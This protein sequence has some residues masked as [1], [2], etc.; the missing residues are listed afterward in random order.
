MGGHALK[1]KRIV[2]AAYEQ[3]KKEIA[4]LFRDQE[5]V[6]IPEAPEKQDYG[7]LDI[8]YKAESDFGKNIYQY[9]KEIL[10][11]RE[12]V[13]NGDVYSCDY[14]DFQIDFIRCSNFEMSQF[15]FSYGDFG[16]ILG[17]IVNQY[18]LKFGQQGLWMNIH[19]DEGKTH[20]HGRI[21][22][23]NEPKQ[24]CDFLG[25]KYEIWKAGFI[26][27]QD[28]F[29]FVS[30]CRLFHPTIFRPLNNRTQKR[31]MYIE[32]LDFIAVLPRPQQQHTQER[33]ALQDEALDFF[34]KRP[35]YTKMMD[36]LETQ[37]QRKEKY[38]GRIFFDLGIP[39]RS[40]GHAMEAFKD[41]HPQLDEWIDQNTAA[42]ILSAIQNFCLTYKN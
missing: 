16:G 36:D 33:R 42:T 31:T 40:I 14:K 24:I 9:I 28:I 4:L 7:D 32:F 20:S 25:L 18:N 21:I 6:F 1:T 2:P 19:L 12:I 29:K 39:E 35:I 23:S 37:R 17:C 8:L 30:Q 38:N 5:I 22:L 34:V 11:P 15:Y 26:S 13:H 27:K 41:Q 10:N 3:I